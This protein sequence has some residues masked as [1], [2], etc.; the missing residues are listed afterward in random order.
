MLKAAVATTP[1]ANEM[2]NAARLSSGEVAL[3][4]KILFWF[5]NFWLVLKRLDERNQLSAGLALICA[6]GH[7]QV[8]AQLLFQLS[9][10]AFRTD[11]MNT[12]QPISNDWQNLV[13]VCNQP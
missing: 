13:W 10:Q 4:I 1:A 6:S 3:F 7:S 11:D 9:L 12:W 2:A 8:I 5:E